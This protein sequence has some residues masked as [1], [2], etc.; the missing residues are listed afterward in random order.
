MSATPFQSAA[1]AVPPNRFHRLIRC[2]PQNQPQA[3]FQSL[4]AL[5]RLSRDQR[6][7]IRF[8]IPR[9]SSRE[10]AWVSRFLPEEE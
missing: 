1:K 2:D 7:A 8:S 4:P 10:R 9:P 6:M 3:K 5:K